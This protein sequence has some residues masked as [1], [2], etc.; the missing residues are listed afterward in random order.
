MS[1]LLG[2]F[3]V[4]G[5]VIYALLMREVLTRYGR[6]NIGFLWLFVEPMMFTLGVA[7]L[8]TLFHAVHGSSLPIVAFAITGYSSILLWRNMAFRTLGAIEPN[9]SLLHHRNIKVFDIY[10]SR[11]LL[12]LIGATASFLV[13]SVAF[14]IL[15]TSLTWP[16]NLLQLIGGWTL[17]AWFGIA[18]AIL[19]GALSED[20]EMVDK[21]FHP[22]QYLF[23]PLSGA[24]FQVD[25][26]PHAA[27]EWALY[28]PTVSGLEIVREGFFGSKFH[29]HYDVGYVVI[30][31]TVMTFA[32]LLQLR[33]V[34][35]EVAP[36]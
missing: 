28:L 29:A 5:R 18:L 24:A 27:Q 10:L 33:K 35:R 23:I 34:S 4:E 8:W 32:G 31:N 1:D 26:L 30:V 19:V 11:L 22:A 7:S 15:T 21:I 3:R 14:G 13:L 25:S 2:S 9:R 12:E 20:Y 36:E 16:E 17:L 6:H